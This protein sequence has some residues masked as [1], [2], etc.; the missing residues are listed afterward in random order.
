[1]KKRY[2]SKKK[3]STQYK[4]GDYIMVKNFDSTGGG[5]YVIEKILK[6]DRFLIKD[7]EGFQLARNPYQGVWS[8][9]NIKHWIGN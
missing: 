5:P 6:N 4:V 3:T 9:Q 2:N 8:S 7:V 1:M